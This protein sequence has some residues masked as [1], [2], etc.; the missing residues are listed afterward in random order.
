MIKL[1]V[2]E[3]CHDCDGFEADV[4][5]PQHAYDMHGNPIYSSDTLVRCGR[6]KLCKNIER[7]LERKMKG[8]NT[9]A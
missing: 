8:E 1:D 7:Y 4:E 5:H 9:N 6:R 2:Q 3:Y